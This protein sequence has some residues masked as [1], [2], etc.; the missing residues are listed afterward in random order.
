HSRGMVNS[1]IFREDADPIAFL[2]ASGD[3]EGGAEASAD[4]FTDKWSRV[5][6]FAR[7]GSFDTVEDDGQMSSEEAS[8]ASAHVRPVSQHEEVADHDWMESAW[9]SRYQCPDS[10]GEM[11]SVSRAKARR[12][13]EAPEEEEE[14]EAD[15][16]VETTETD[17]G[18]ITQAAIDP[19]EESAI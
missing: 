10:F 13:E 19:D 16:R 3:S 6:S 12:G 5:E 2:N 8:S 15:H 18:R 7:T 9:R 1:I 11:S 14:E 17:R 4:Y